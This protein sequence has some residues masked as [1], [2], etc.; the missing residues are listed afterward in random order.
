MQKKFLWFI[1]CDTLLSYLV[2]YN[3]RMNAR[4]QFKDISSF[5]EFSKYYWYREDL[6]K[7][8]KALGLDSGGMKAELNR[9]IEEYFKG[10]RILPKPKSA[11]GAAGRPSAVGLPCAAPK[12]KNRAAASNAA[13]GQ[14]TLKTDLV[15]CGFKF[16]QRA[17]DFFSSQTGIKNFK[18]NADM[19]A[20][21]K[22][23]KETGD[24]S[25]TLGD[26]LD[27]YYGKKT[28]A[29]YD[30]VSLQWNKFVQDFC[31]DPATAAFPNK[32]KSAAALWKIVRDSDRPKV[33]AHSLLEEFKEEL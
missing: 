26:L 10:N 16:N 3:K 24:E 27:V 11:S 12:P 30:K 21:V 33:Y 22:K 18:F 28:Y 31:A 29:R 23:V 20:T 8:C 6:K 1:K 32:L 19:V 14:L 15:A 4:P 5:E 2:C 13:S 7:I 17:R 9:V 25:F